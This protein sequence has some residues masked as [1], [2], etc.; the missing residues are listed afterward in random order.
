MTDTTITITH[1]NTPLP[2][3]T[4]LDAR[5]STAPTEQYNSITSRHFGVRHPP[6]QSRLGTGDRQGTQPGNAF[7]I[8]F[9]GWTVR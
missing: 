2:S 9:L 6:A 4:P 1:N 3:P 5:V 7:T 8:I